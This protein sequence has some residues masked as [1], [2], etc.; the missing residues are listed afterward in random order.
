ME[1]HLPIDE[2]Q[3]L[4][5]AGCPRVEVRVLF[6][7]VEVLS[8]PVAGRR[9][10]LSAS[11][12]FRFWLDGVLLAEGPSRSDPELWGVVAAD[13]PA[14]GP[15]RHVYAVEVVQWGRAGGKGQIGPAGFLLFAGVTLDWRAVRD[16]AWVPNFGNEKPQLSEHRKIGLGERFCAA[17]YP[18]GWQTAGEGFDWPGVVA[19]G[20]TPGNPWGNR[21]LNCS[22]VMEP[23]P[24]LRREGWAWRR[25]HC[26]GVEAGR[27]E[28]FVLDAGVVLNAVPRVA[29]S[30]GTGG[31]IRLVWCEAPVQAD[32]GKGN[33][34]EM[35]GCRFP[36]QEDVLEPDG[37]E[38]RSWQPPWIRSFRYL[39]IEVTTGET[40]LRALA[41]S[42]ER[43]SFPL[44]PRL[45]VRVVDPEGRPWA[46][47]RQVSLDTAL[48]CSHETF[49]DC[50]AWE[51]AQFPGDSRIQARHHYVLANED[52]LARKAIRDLAAQR[53]P[54]GL[55]LSHAP[56]SFRQVIATYSLA[57]VGMLHEFRVFRGDAA[58]LHAFLPVARGILEW[59]LEKKRG[60]GLMGRVAE[61]L[62]IDWTPGFEAG[63]LPQEAAGGS[64]GLT[65]MVAEACQWMTGLEIFAGRE[66]LAGE[67]CREAQELM[68]ALRQVPRTAEGL[69]PDTPG[70]GLSLHTQ[71]QA[72]LAGVWKPE[73][74][75]RVLEAAVK[76]P[77]V[78]PAG[79]LYY[80]SFVAEAFRRAGAG[81]RVWDLVTDSFRM[82]E[83]TGLTTWPESDR[84]PRSDCHGWG[85][86]PELELVQTV[87]GLTADPACSGWGRVVFAPHPGRLRR[88][89]GRVPH[90]AGVLTLGMETQG[91]AL[92]V[93]LDSPVPVW[94][95]GLEQQFPAGEHAFVLPMPAGQLSETGAEYDDAD[96]SS[97]LSC[98]P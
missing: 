7:A 87:M 95:P 46:R 73:A 53:M 42:L 24:P 43:Q 50:P 57:W 36:G 48:A 64:V 72:F 8:E 69:L 27:V 38:G 56:S 90:P 9:V 93:R 96:S 19:F 21:P 59:F 31:R 51:Q 67:W 16:A 80:R 22:F 58:F 74:G 55:L 85:Q 76:N 97:A 13:L 10:W 23:L 75:R 88:I 63:C 71:V 41:V 89:E 40:P 92:K 4:W 25:G 86:M 11:H 28:T 78:R 98:S 6:R 12:R 44:T 3:P 30:G 1:S 68:C 18:W 2:V 17:A 61:P 79:T 45:D 52:R 65:A 91:R 94:V 33:R 15:G 83:G 47:M 20:E 49:F 26:G 32:G 84:R 14:M 5:A 29:W 66:S 77:E 81:G 62:F 82:L 60:D 34:D 35:A 37:G 70:G 39:W 54:T